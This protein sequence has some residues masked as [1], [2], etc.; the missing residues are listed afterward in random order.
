MTCLHP[1]IV[2]REPI[3]RES[4]VNVEEVCADCGEAVAVTSWTKDAW[5]HHQ[6]KR[7]ADV[8]QAS[9]F[10]EREAE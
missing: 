9:L 8:Q 1:R 4:C 5:I 6:M 10:S 7:I 2:K 3:A